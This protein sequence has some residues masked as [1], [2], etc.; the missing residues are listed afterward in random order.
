[1]SFRLHVQFIVSHGECI[2][3]NTKNNDKK[4]NHRSQ[5]PYFSASVSRVGNCLRLITVRTSYL[6]VA[7]K[8]KLQ[9]N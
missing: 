7:I 3:I 4:S 9:I 1:M 5:K 6:S 8:Q 2:D